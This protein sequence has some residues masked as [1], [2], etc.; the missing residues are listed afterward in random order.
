LTNRALVLAALADGNCRLS[1]IL[2]A[3]DTQVM[4]DSLGRLGFDLELDWAAR[5]LTVGGRSGKIPAHQ[6]EL[7]CGNSGTTIRF[8]AAM[9][10]LGEGQYDLDGVARMRQRPIG[11]LIDLLRNL[12]VRSEY[13]G[14][15]GYP[16]IRVFGG[17]LPGGLLR[18]GSAMSSQFL[19]A[20]LMI[21]PFARHEVQIDLEGRQTSWPYV[22][23]TMRLM[24]H[25]GHT[26]E[27]VRDR[28]TGEPR[29]IVVPRGNYLASDYVVEPDASNAGYF[30]A[31]AAIQPGA[32][33]TIENLGKS[34][35]Q[36][37]VGLADLLHRM[38]AD[39]VFGSDFITM[40]GTERLEG[41]EADL[42]DMPDVAQTLAAVALF[43]E[44]PTSLSGLHTLRVKE[45]DR[46]TA[47]QTELTKL[48]A[49]VTI[50]QNTLHI[51]PPEKIVPAGIDTYE[52][53]RMAMSFAVVGTRAQGV[54]IRDIECTAK[55]YPKFFDDLK[56][57]GA[58]ESP[59]AA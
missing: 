55:T 36:G 26:P 11:E 7:A 9:C 51:E 30:L 56:A 42:S 15:P 24:D 54:T 2:L 20:V 58:M 45:T 43:A 41:I 17:D 23:M 48:G 16:P 6:A 1:N 18:Y 22:A 13:L 53:H 4:I 49:T 12:G 59:A 14:A 35:L 47:L 21:A 25:F 46:L 38:G 37:D 39:L 28:D 33:I 8:L 52:D 31:A 5:T 27:L 40:T 32:K 34:S 44:G 3:D 19:S 50:E 10:A 57:I 29:Q